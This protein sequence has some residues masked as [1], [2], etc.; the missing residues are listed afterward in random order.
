MVGCC[1]SIRARRR[2]GRYGFG[3]CRR[4]PGRWHSR[5]GR[6]ATRPGRARTVKGEQRER[7]ARLPS[8]SSTSTAPSS[9]AHHPVQAAHAHVADLPDQVD[10]RSD[11]LGD[12]G[13]D[14]RAEAPAR[15][16]NRPLRCR[17]RPPARR[18]TDGPG[19][20]QH[21]GQPDPVGARRTRVLVAARRS[22][23]RPGGRCQGAARAHRIDHDGEVGAVP[24]SQQVERVDDGPDVARR[25]S[26]EPRHAPATTG[27][28]PSS[29]RYSFPRPGHHDAR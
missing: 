2:L 23:S 21:P 16:R 10:D 6:Q 24:S 17:P 19:E 28:A 8:R 9:A 5:C 4:R 26:L 15:C 7:G 20:T 1:P 22:Q 11:G 18:L 29:R 3:F 13:I 12:G 14:G 25:R 27:P